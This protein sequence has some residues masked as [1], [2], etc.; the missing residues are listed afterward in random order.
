MRKIIKKIIYFFKN[1]VNVISD[2]LNFNVI[3]II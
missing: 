1:T 3:A 2:E